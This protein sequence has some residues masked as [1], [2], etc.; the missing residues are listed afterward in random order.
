MKTK[1]QLKNHDTLTYYCMLMESIKIT[2]EKM[3]VKPTELTFPKSWVMSE[4]FMT[5]YHATKLL[6]AC[7]NLGLFHKV[8]NRYQVASKSILLD[9]ML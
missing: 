4:L 2:S 8:S 9:M 6:D 3:E 1:K 5:R 7:V